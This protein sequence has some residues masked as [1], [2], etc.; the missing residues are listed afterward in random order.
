VQGFLESGADRL[1]DKIALI[2]DGQHLTYSAIEARANRLANALQARGLRRGERVVTYLATMLNCQGALKAVRRLVKQ[3]ENGYPY[4]D[5]AS[6]LEG[7][8][9]DSTNVLE[10]VMFVE[11]KFDIRHYAG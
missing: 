7:S 10:L 3:A 9:V 11:A 8:I 2:C 5:D 1:T 4:S 6:L